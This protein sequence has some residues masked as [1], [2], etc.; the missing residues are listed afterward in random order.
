[1]VVFRAG[2]A[3]KEMVWMAMGEMQM[4]AAAQERMPAVKEVQRV[5]RGVSAVVEIPSGKMAQAAV[6]GMMRV[7][8]KALAV[9]VTSAVAQ[10]VAQRETTGAWAVSKAEAQKEAVGQKELE[11]TVAVKV[12]EMEYHTPHWL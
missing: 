9:K 5:V 6:A 7:D 12:E 10:Q 8:V 4:A 3:L 1:M 11:P 2:P